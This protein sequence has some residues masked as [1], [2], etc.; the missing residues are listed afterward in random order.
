MS[1]LGSPD[2]EYDVRVSGAN[3]DIDLALLTQEG[4]DAGPDV[5]PIPLGTRIVSSPERKPL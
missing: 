3:A 4:Q 1:Y 5:A 2:E